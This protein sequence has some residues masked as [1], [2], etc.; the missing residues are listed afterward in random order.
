MAAICVGCYTVWEI[1]GFVYLGRGR[2]VVMYKYCEFEGCSFIEFMVQ[3]HL[4]QVVF[5]PCGVELVGEPPIN[6]YHS[7]YARGGD[8]VGILDLEFSKNEPLLMYNFHSGEGWPCDDSPPATRDS[9]FDLL[10]GDSAWL[11]RPKYWDNPP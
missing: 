6:N 10:H 7:V 9:L 1:P 4:S 2:S 3:D 11:Q 5:G 8:V